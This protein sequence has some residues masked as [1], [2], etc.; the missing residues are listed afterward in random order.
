MKQ[1]NRNIPKMRNRR[2][3]RSSRYNRAVNKN[4]L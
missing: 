2:K 3:S 4:D 1:L